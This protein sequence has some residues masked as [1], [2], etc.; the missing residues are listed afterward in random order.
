LLHNEKLRDLKSF[1]LML[2]PTNWIKNGFIVFPLV[3]SHNLFHQEKFSAIFISIVAFS[4][5]SSTVYIINDII[6]KDADRLHERKSKRPIASGEISI[7][8]ALLSASFLGLI[9]FSIV[10]FFNNLS[11]ALIFILYFVLNLLYCFWL[12]RINLIESFV[13]PFNFILRILVGCFSISVVPSSWILAV[14]FFVSLFLTFIKRKSELQVVDFE[15]NKHRAVLSGY[16]VE[17][18]N[19]YIFMCATITVVTYMLY[20]LESPTLSTVS[21]NRLFYTSPLV[22]LGLLRFIQLSYNGTYS[23]EG[24]PTILIF[25]DRFLQSIVSVWILLIIGLLYF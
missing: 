24:D 3:F 17:L 15:S 6:D 18:L 23:K 5:L 1:L 20:T 8:T 7:F 16:T 10:F 11:T 19:I 4:F 13:I 14:T 25:K 12:K 9:A 21:S 2:R 22:L